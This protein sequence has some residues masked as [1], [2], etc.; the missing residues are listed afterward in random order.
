[1]WDMIYKHRQQPSELPLL[2][3]LH[4]RMNLSAEDKKYYFNLEKG[5]EGELRFDLFAKELTC[6]C[7]ILHD[8]LLTS[9]NTTF[10]IDSLMITAETIFI[11]EV[12]NFSGDY[13]YESEKFFNMRGTEILNPLHQVSRTASL[14]RSLLFK[15][16]FNLPVDCKVIFINEHFT[17]YQAPVNDTL[18]HPTQL[19]TYF[20]KL[21]TLPFL[22][23][24]RHHLLAEKLLE[25]QLDASPVKPKLPSYQYDQLEKGI[26]C[27]KCHSFSVFV[28]GRKCVCNNCTH[29]EI[30][31]SAVV[32]AA[33]EFKLLFPKE[34]MSTGIVH[35]W[36]SIVRS[37]KRIKYIL[38]K[39]FNAAG[40]NRW[41]YYE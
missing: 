37:K 35:D 40:K 22:L 27:A 8:L 6:E 9:N 26:S 23:T 30:V 24:K 32:R 39:N 33:K 19:K 7:L 14:L 21:N 15:Q 38:D 20:H 13:Y 3:C 12:K 11:Y 41:L 4:T 16:G 5:F 18:I 17:L 10:Q 1:M 2:R 25:L 31:E 29:E 28:D 34:K 36:C